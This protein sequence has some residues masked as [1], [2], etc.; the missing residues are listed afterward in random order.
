MLLTKRWNVI[1]ENINKQQAIKEAALLLKNGSLVAFPTET[2]YGLGADATNEKAV[3]AVFEAKGRPQDNPLIAH[4][5]TKEQ[6]LRLVSHM[7]AYVDKLI[8]AFSPGPI[9]YVLPSSGKCAVNVTA[10]LSTIAVRIPDHEIAQAL[11]KE[12]DIPIAAPSANTS[13]KP[14]PTAA[15]H[16]WEDLFGKI[17]G[18]LDGGPT[19]VGMESTVIDCTG[20]V[21]VILRPGGITREELE[22]VVGFVDVSSGLE[23]EKDKPTSPGM[24]YRHYSPDLPLWLVDGSIDELQAFVVKERQRG[25]RVGLLVRNQTAK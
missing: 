6:L 15:D 10:G 1:D 17:A 22:S 4:V 23:N 20:D 25:R 2:V 14:S 3:S 18:V 21:P 9:T 13:G 8:D 12:C 16:V 19:G 11:L 5:A 24:K 7:P